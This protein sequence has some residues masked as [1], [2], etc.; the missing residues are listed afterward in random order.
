MEQDGTLHVSAETVHTLADNGLIDAQSHAYALQRIGKTPSLASWRRWIDIA[1][2]VLGVGFLLAGIFF[3]FAYNWQSLP[4]FGKLAIVQ[5]L[6]VVAAAVAYWRGLDDRIGQT[7][8]TAA[9][10]LLGALLAVYGQVYQTGADSYQLFLWWAILSAGWVAISRFEPLWLAW[11]GL[12]NVAIFATWVQLSERWVS[13][14]FI[15][16]FLLN[17][18]VLAWWER[19]GRTSPYRYW[20][21][22]VLLAAFGLVLFPTLTFIAE[23][24]YISDEPFMWGVVALYLL[25][26]AGCVYF[27]RK[28]VRDLFP[29]AM[30]GIGIIIV[31]ITLLLQIAG[32]SSFIVFFI[33]AGIVLGGSVLLVRWLQQ[34]SSGWE[35]A[36]AA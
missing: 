10:I 19:S 11:L 21:R 28:H 6:I 12:L 34:T 8:L 27:Y 13:L 26:S 14:L 32:D 3:F 16:L 24:F 29:L 9:A 20:P 36:D 15:S 1:L 23:D 33:A 7:A 25:F 5:V 17:F 30:V 4:K 35:V 18:A 2:L 22:A 31:C